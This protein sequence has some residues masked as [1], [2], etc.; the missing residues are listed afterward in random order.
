[1]KKLGLVLVAFLA[2][3]SLTG[4]GGKKVKCT[5]TE[6]GE[7][8]TL[9]GVFKDDKL[10][11]YEAEMTETFETEEEAEQGYALLQLTSGLMGSIEG[12]ELKV[13]KS[14][15]KVTMKMTADISKMSTEDAEDLLDGKIMSMSEFKT[16]MEEDGFTCK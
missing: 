1:M 4:C 2:V 13:D 9:V 12:V 7:K 15:K 10:V 16:S 11:K 3:F 5:R 6:D 8:Q 14:G